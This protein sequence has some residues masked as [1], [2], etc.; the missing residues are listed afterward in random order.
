MA[1][2][3]FFKVNLQLERFVRALVD[4]C[5]AVD[6]VLL[7][8]DCD[9]VHLDCTVRADVLASSAT[10]TVLFLYLHDHGYNTLARTNLE[11]PIK[12]LRCYYSK[13]RNHLTTSTG[14]LD[15]REMV[16][17]TLPTKALRAAFMPRLPTMIMLGWK[18][19]A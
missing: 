10:D 9:L 1:G 19:A 17:E 14:C 18:F 15:L 16:E 6:T 4:A 5:T 2:W 13:C 8:D 3:K 12:P 7:G 11:F